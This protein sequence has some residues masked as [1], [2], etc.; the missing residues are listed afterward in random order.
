M[1]VSKLLSGINILWLI[2]R[3]GTL[4]EVSVLQRT[5]QVT[6][7]TQATSRISEMSHSRDKSYRQGSLLPTAVATFF[8][9]KGS[10]ELC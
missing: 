8:C 6:L 4:P 9:L 10:L 2:C 3:E 5:A 1:L 7:R